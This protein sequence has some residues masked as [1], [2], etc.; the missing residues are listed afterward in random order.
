VP[1]ADGCKQGSFFAPLAVELESLSELT[2]EHFGPVLHVLRFSAQRIDALMDAI[3]GL[4]FGLTLGI[5]SRIEGTW[6]RLQAR[7]RV[8]NCYVNRGMTG[9]V[10]GVQPFGGEGLSGTG[11]KAGGPHY[12]L[13]L[14]VE[15][16][17]SVN[18]AAIGGDTRLLRESL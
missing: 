2:E 3:N 5:Y 13:R 16:S 12:L 11:P 4:R 10:V 17:V 7:A 6:R 1:L 9:A 8:G 14:V 18:T 15:R